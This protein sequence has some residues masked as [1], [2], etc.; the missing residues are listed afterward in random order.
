VLSQV[1][2]GN[3]PV[4]PGSTVTITVGQKPAPPGT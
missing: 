1:P 4:D 2:I 3:K